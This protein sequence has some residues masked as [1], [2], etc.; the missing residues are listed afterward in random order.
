MPASHF[1]SCLCW[2]ARDV[3]RHPMPLS[4]ASVWAELSEPQRLPFSLCTFSPQLSYNSQALFAHL[5]LSLELLGVWISCK[6]APGSIPRCLML[7]AQGLH[8]FFQPFEDTFCVVLW[9]LTGFF[10]SSPRDDP[11][12]S[13]FPALQPVSH[14]LSFPVEL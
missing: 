3:F 14:A 2:Q 6:E 12:S 11:S 10:S 4:C 13:G 1:S 8:P 7:C 9:P 5:P